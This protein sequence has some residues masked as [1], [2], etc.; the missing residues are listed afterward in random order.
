MR[1]QTQALRKS[2]PHERIICGKR[3][4]T[5]DIKSSPMKSTGIESLGKG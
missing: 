4:C 5:E 2:H 3:L 1:R